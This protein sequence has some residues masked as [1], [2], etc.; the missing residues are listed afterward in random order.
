MIDTALLLID[1]QK[2]FWDPYKEMKEYSRL[3]GNVKHLRKHFKEKGQPVIHV[4]SVFKEDRSDWI[5]F[6]RPEGRGTIPCIMGTDGVGFEEFS[7]PSE[8]E[9]IF[10]KTVFD[11][12]NG[13]RLLAYLTDIGVKTLVVSGIETSVCVLFTATSAYLNGLLPVVVVDACADSPERH[14]TTIEMYSDLCFKTLT[15]SQITGEPKELETLIE[16]FT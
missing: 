4:H 14:K 5:L 1:I 11:A 8:S 6:Y 7:E 15:T 2:D 9:K 10:K 16:K 3:P 12:F 13:T